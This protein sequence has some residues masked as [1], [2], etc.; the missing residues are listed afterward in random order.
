MSYQLDQS[1]HVLGSQCDLFIKSESIPRIPDTRMEI[2]FNNILDIL[3]DW[4]GIIKD[5]I[6]LSEA[7]TM[8]HTVNFTLI[9][10]AAY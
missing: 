3:S 4:R 9:F 10:A 7:I 5:D 6:P 1:L 2:H 8:A